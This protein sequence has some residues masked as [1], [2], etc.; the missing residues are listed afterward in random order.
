MEIK[1]LGRVLTGHTTKIIVIALLIAG[2]FA[3]QGQ[4]TPGDVYEVHATVETEAV[5]TSDGP[6]D[7]AIWIHPDDPARSTVITTDKGFG[8]QPGGG[9]RVYDLNGDEIQYIAGVQPNNVDLRYNFPLDGESVSLVTAGNRTDNTIIIYKVDVNTR[10]LEDV[11][12]RLIPVELPEAY[13]SC[14]YHSPISGAY[15]VFINTKKKGGVTQ[16]QLFNNGNGKVDAQL[17]RSF[18]VGSQ[19]EGCVAD[20][21]LGDLYI[22]E[23]ERGIWKYNAE[24][25]GDNARTLVDKAGSDGPLVKDV[26]GL[27]LYYA[28]EDTGYLIASSQGSSRFVVYERQGSN[29]YVGTF[30]ISAS[31]NV[32]GVSGTDGIDVTNVAL[33]EH[34]PAGLLVAQDQNNSDVRGTQ[35]FKLISW[36]DLGNSFESKLVIDTSWNP[37]LIGTE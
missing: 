5:V 7:P 26:E 4:R 9:L 33:N 29:A 17:V 14:M 19:T 2:L 8:S 11:T 32:D 16:F 12:A 6:D 28:N 22:G 25:D 3:C 31:D 34:F 20:D 21:V 24:P 18:E 37:R 10:Q 15:Y 27:T 13:G 35:N 30:R 1:K 36:Q 23:E